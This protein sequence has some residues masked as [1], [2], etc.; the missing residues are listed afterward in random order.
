[1]LVV[2]SFGCPLTVADETLTPVL[3]EQAEPALAAVLEK[4]ISAQLYRPPFGSPF[5]TT[6][7]VAF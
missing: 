4:V 1:M 3:F 7:I 6:W 2:V 5:V